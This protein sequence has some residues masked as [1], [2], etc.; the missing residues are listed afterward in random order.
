MNKNYWKSLAAIF[1][2]SLL[3]VV[4]ES[5]SID[6]DTQEQEN[7]GNTENVVEELRVAMN[8][9]PPTLD[10]LIDPTIVT[11]DAA[12]LIFETLFTVDSDF[13]PV[14]LLAESVET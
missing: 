9:S 5:D 6:E 12:I 2:F 13:Q 7:D 3:L 11:R 10:Q 1:M 8:A 14:P 4:C